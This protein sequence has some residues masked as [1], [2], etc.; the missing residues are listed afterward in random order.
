MVS[1]GR[2][3]NAYQ[4]ELK[5]SQFLIGQSYC[6]QL[7]DGGTILKPTLQTAN[8][9]QRNYL[10]F[11]HDPYKCNSVLFLLFPLE[12]QIPKVVVE[13]REFLVD[14]IKTPPQSTSYK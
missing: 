1:L 4:R 7:R 8:N 2:A 13:F 14:S 5:K 12:S 9:Q 11:L 6:R 3:D 10:I